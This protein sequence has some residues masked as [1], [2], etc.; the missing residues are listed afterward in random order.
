MQFKNVVGAKRDALGDSLY[1]LLCCPDV[2]D[3]RLPLGILDALVGNENVDQFQFS[4]ADAGRPKRLI[5]FQG[6][7]D[8]PYLLGQDYPPSRSD[9]VESPTNQRISRPCRRNHCYCSVS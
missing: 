1:P 3:L 7:P 4:N 9:P 5:A 8:L 2:H 6:Q